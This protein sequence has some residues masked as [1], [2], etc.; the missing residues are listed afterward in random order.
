MWAI[1]DSGMK[2][3][4]IDARCVGPNSV[5]A[6]FLLP[7]W[8][9]NFQANGKLV[10]FFVIFF[11]ICTISDYFGERTTRLGFLS[12][13]QTHRYETVRKQI[14]NWLVHQDFRKSHGTTRVGE[15]STKEK[16]I[17]DTTTC[18]AE[19]HRME[20]SKEDDQN[21]VQ[22]SLDSGRG[23]PQPKR[24]ESELVCSKFSFLL[25]AEVRFSSLSHNFVSQSFR[26]S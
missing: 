10:W 7:E 4:W 17:N 22:D 16:L 2:P 6:D 11:V 26:D 20:S 18:E 14:F 13:L 19:N 21:Q 1:Q 24:R 3:V 25:V 23:T 5:D 15:R 9:W 8:E 12:A